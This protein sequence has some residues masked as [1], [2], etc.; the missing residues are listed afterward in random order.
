MMFGELGALRDM[1]KLPEEERKKRAEDYYTKIE[2][3]AIPKD[4]PI[5]ALEPEGNID[6]AKQ[7]YL[8]PILEHAP[9]EIGVIPIISVPV[10]T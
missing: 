2:T 4:F 1:V 6:I 10:S 5:T 3:K 7:F 9:I 8:L